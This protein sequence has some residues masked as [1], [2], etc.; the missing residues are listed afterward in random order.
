MGHVLE[1]GG[2]SLFRKGK[3]KRETEWKEGKDAY[4]KERRYHTAQKHRT[5]THTHTHTHT[6][7]YTDA[8]G[9]PNITQRPPISVYVLASVP[10]MYSVDPVGERTVKSGLHTISGMPVRVVCACMFV[11]A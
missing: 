3:G 11:P 10:G 9:F 6:L 8:V 1:P 5:N 4:K 7:V 2:R